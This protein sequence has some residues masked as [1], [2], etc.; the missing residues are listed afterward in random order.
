MTLK[1]AEEP[2]NPLFRYIAMWI[3]RDHLNIGLMF[4]RSVYDL[5]VK[6]GFFP[7]LDPKSSTQKL[8]EKIKGVQEPDLMLEYKGIQF[9]V[10]CLYRTSFSG[11]SLSLYDKQEYQEREATYAVLT[12]PLFIAVGIGGTPECPDTFL[13]DYH[14]YFNMTRMSRDQCRRVTTHFRGDFIEYKVRE[15]FLKKKLL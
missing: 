11:N 14:T 15:T 5:M 10:D 1:N 2:F 6:H 4:E 13:F 7:A 12:D 9:W 3:S 8:D